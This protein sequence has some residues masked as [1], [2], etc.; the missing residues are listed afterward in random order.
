MTGSNADQRVNGLSAQVRVVNADDASVDRVAVAT[1]A[2]DD[3]IDATQL[4]APAGIRV[5]A[6]DGDDIAVG[7]S[8]DDSLFGNA[9]DDILIG[10][11]GHDELNGGPGDDI[12]LGG[13]VVVDGLVADQKWLARHTRSIRGG[14]TEFDLGGK[15]LNVPVQRSALR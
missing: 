7:G 9:G 5:E 4:S 14:G 1:L 2:A 3:V 13:E 10:G 15:R 8:G 11:L 6:G 12:L